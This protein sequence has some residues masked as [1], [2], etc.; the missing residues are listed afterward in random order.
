M[1]SFNRL[2]VQVTLAL[3]LEDSSV[4]TIGEGAGV[5]RAQTGQVVLVA[6]ECLFDSLLLEGTV[7]CGNDLP[8]NVVLNHL[9]LFVCVSYEW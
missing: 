6:T 4:A 2:H 5:S 3:L 7:A 1:S 8:D 9:Y